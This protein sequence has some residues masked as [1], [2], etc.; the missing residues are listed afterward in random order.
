LKRIAQKTDRGLQSIERKNTAINRKKKKKLINSKNRQTNKID[1][2]R[3]VVV[4]GN[5]RSN[6]K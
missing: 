6:D 2:K 5:K 1:P 4:G 3:Q